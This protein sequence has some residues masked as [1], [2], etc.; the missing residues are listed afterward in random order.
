MQ[1]I[2]R[3]CAGLAIAG[4]LALAGCA[5]G[6]QGKTINVP[7]AAAQEVPPNDSKGSGAAALTLDP[8]AKKITWKVTWQNL[9]GDAAAA[10]LHGPAAPG[11]NAG[12]VVPLGGAGPLKS[13]LEGSATLNDQQWA[14]LMAGKDY[15]NV[16]TAANKGG[17]IRGQVTP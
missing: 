4:S 8:A 9:T 15:I 12:V 3:L 17:E 1:H 13:P 5:Q 11:A 2:M 6:P 10:H 16:H 14:D 7:L